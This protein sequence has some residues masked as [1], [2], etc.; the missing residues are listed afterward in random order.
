[1][2]IAFLH[3]SDIHFEDNK[4]W[5][6]NKASLIAKSAVGSVFE[7][8]IKALF[9]IVSGDVANKGSKSQYDIAEKFFYEIYYHL[10]TELSCPIKFVF[11]PGNHDCDLS[12]KS[13]ARARITIIE[14]ILKDSTP[15]TTE[16]KM[17]RQCLDVQKNF[18]EF[19]SQFNDD[20]AKFPDKPEIFY[21]L[22]FQIEDKQVDF[23]CYNT[24]WLTQLIESPGK[25]LMPDFLLGEANKKSKADITFS[26][27]HHPENWLSPN[28]N[29]YFHDLIA[30]TSDIAISGHEHTSNKTLELQIGKTTSTQI[31]RAAAI[32]DRD[33]PNTSTYD[34]ILID[35]EK[36]KERID[37]YQWSDDSYSRINRADW[38][39]FVKNKALAKQSFP[40][41]PQFHHGLRQM[42]T[43]PINHPRKMNIE[44][45]DFFVAPKLQIYSLEKFI[46]GK[47]NTD[48]TVEQKNFLKFIQEKKKVILYGETLQGKTTLI[49]Y[50]SL[51]LYEQNMV[52]I[53]LLG[54]NLVGKKENTVFRAIRT[55]FEEQYNVDQY[56]KFEQLPKDKKAVLIDDFGQSVLNQEQLQ[57][58]L[59]ALSEKFGVVIAAAHSNLTIQQYLENESGK[60]RFS[61]FTHCII[62]PLNKTQ[63]FEFIKNWVMLGNEGGSSE[64]IQEIKLCEQNVESSLQ[65][66][67]M[68]PY[69]IYVTGALQLGA[70]TKQT[71]LADK[72]KYRT[73]GQLYDNLI[74]NRF[75]VLED[76]NLDL[77][78][79][80][81]LL[82]EMATH[83]Y[84]S[85]SLNIS[86]E[87][88][89]QIIDKYQSIFIETL[90]APKF[91]K[92]LTESGIIQQRGAQ[93]YFVNHHLR[94]FF[95][96]E[97]FL[98]L[99]GSESAEAKLQTQK[100]IDFIIKRLTYES[101]T[102]ILLFLVYK[103]YN[104]P[105]FIR[106]ILSFS[107]QIFK[108]YKPVDLRTDTTF[109]KDLHKHIGSPLILEGTFLEKR[110]ELNK[111]IDEKEEEDSFE[112]VRYQN[113]DQFLEEYDENSDIFVKSATALKM[114]E[115]LG[116][117][118]RSFSTTLEGGIKEDIVLEAS[119]LGFRFLQA[120]YQIRGDGLEDLRKVLGLLIK[121]RHKDL[122]NGQLIERADNLLLFM[123]FGATYGVIKK[124]SDSVGSPKMKAVYQKIIDARKDSLSFQMLEAALRL[125]H[126][127]DPAAEKI[128]K[129]GEKLDKENKFLWDVL[130]RFVADYLNYNSGK[131]GA[132]RHMLISKFGFNDRPELLLNEEKA[133]RIYQPI[134]RT[135]FNPPETLK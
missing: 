43:I 66:N 84:K 34:V 134:Q 86:T 111:S 128:K 57:N 64:Q 9:I 95:V 109:L 12:D 35:L 76:E 85:E 8:S 6:I 105:E 121:I 39:D 99:L 114:I 49:N 37:S 132:D 1:M 21:R 92:Q 28:N 7:D 13:E 117:L 69:P 19:V 112:L 77:G 113:Q 106:Q 2:K 82:G 62:R 17:Y 131:M 63:R 24:A 10:E 5:V 133:E 90:Y 41:D 51:R 29:N 40:R 127:E 47:K 102:R 3:L 22:G 36:R 79:I 91:I 135:K 120:L 70:H 38:F 61:D 119:E 72:N 71:A 45:D 115:V 58:I 98:R 74:S 59:Q 4:D 122:S 125:E 15:F 68:M 16:D 75:G 94:D 89:T 30:E 101:H 83:C 18:F 54:I 96:A 20:E 88:T 81:L 25:L 31:L 123:F 42:N 26:V 65:V 103:A 87:D 67:M 14:S 11:V 97:H 48:E 126:Y 100:Q 116:Q 130:Q 23:N 93:L 108:E 107:T 129:L 80:Y 55:A 44:I 52:P 33:K 56:E 53:N 32:Q 27:F 104:K 110:N 124:I 60:V 73:I 50:L 118:G 78:Q 46:D